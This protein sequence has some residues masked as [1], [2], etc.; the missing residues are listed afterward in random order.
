MS[1]R[2]QESMPAF[3]ISPIEKEFDLIK[4][5]AEYNN[6]PGSTK[7]RIRQATQAA[8]DRIESLFN[9]IERE[10]N[11]KSPGLV[12]Q[13]QKLSITA[14][15]RLEAFLTI[16]SCNIEAEDGQLLFN[17]ETAKDE[18]KFAEAWGKL[19]PF[20]C[21]EIVDC[22]HEVNISWSPGGN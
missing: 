20:I 18:K 4:T 17:S 15:H 22:I 14:L 13:R 7:L 2:Y 8:N 9:N 10:Y 16:I 21:D 5:D 12:I 6:E 3:R 19:P 11:D 1:N